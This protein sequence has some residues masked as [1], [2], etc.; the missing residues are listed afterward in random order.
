[1]AAT[2]NHVKISMCGAV[3]GEQLPDGFLNPRELLTECRR[4]DEDGLRLLIKQNTHR[5]WVVWG[6]LIRR[7]IVEKI[8]FAA[9]RIYE[10]NAIV[11]QWLHEAGMAADLQ[12]NY[13]FYQVNPEGTTKKQL[14]PKE[15]DNLWALKEQLQFYKMVGYQEL[16][17]LIL[18][19]YFMMA[20]SY[21]RQLR[22]GNFDREITDNL[23]NE[24]RRMY[25]KNRK[26]L[27]FGKD[28]HL[29]ICS[30]IYPKAYHLYELEKGLERRWRSE[31]LIG[32]IKRVLHFK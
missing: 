7:E 28:R 18:D 11:C 6:K 13:Y 9:G 20:V 31:G 24:M 27:Q 32:V 30:V 3:E 16:Y 26:L 23:K 10:D 1:M 25:Q 15:L 8:A 12:E 17:T 14:T 22:N 4:M 5:Y 21:H 2:E 29:L 19:R